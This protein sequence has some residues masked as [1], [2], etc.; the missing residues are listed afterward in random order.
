MPSG[1]GWDKDKVLFKL[2][3]KN[4][5]D[6]VRYVTASDFECLVT[7]SDEE[8]PRQRVPNTQ[9]FHPDRVT[10][11]TCLIAVLKPLVE[12]QDPEEVHLEAYA[13]LGKGR[14]HA[15]FNPTSQ[16]AYMYTLDSDPAKTKALFGT[17][18]QEQKKVDPKDLDK[19]ETR[20]AVL[21]R[22][23][24]SLE[25]YRC[26][27]KDTEGEPYSYDFTVETLGTMSIQK[28][29]Y[30]ALLSVAALADKYAA[31]DTGDLPDSL[32]IRPADAR[33]TGYDFWFSGEDHT[34]GNLLQTWIDT[35]K[36]GR[37]GVT[38]AGYKVPHPLKEEMV[39]RV[40]VE[41]NKQETARLAIA[42]AAQGCADM[43]RTWAMQWLSA[44]E[45]AGLSAVVG[46]RRTVWQAHA[47]S[48]SLPATSTATAAAP[49]GRAR[50]AKLPKTTGSDK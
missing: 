47:N 48:K 50:P 19:D 29:V 43:F 35:N 11:E 6:E 5:T 3:V 27:L 46:E 45:D 12:G 26:Y 15:R 10:G 42:E 16:C 30:Q 7:N 37:D 21:E 17:W 34:L 36:V 32:E 38:F 41:D 25:I 39:L 14:E 44:A 33:L 20:K 13:T 1:E 24:R 23:F 40:G 8:L 31:I 18:L 22:E 4:E 49:K 2:H 28:I 9:Y